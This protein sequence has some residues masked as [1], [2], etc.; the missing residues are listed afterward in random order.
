MP[1][2]VIR[3]RSF[4]VQRKLWKEGTRLYIIRAHIEPRRVR[5]AIRP[6]RACTCG[7]SPKIGE[8]SK[9]THRQ[10]GRRVRGRNCHA[11]EINPICPWTTDKDLLV[12]LA[13][14]VPVHS[15]ISFR[16]NECM[17]G[18]WC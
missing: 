17:K 6:G 11:N 1:N 9:E 5:V 8:R 10:A 18:R 14:I 2:D 12:R 3:K 7:I 15:M 16:A 4:S 13:E